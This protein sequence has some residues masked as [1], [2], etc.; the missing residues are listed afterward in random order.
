MDFEDTL[1][2]KHPDGNIEEVYVNN[3]I[4]YDRIR[5]L[6]AYDECDIYRHNAAA[7]NLR[8]TDTIFTVKK[9]STGE[10]VG[11]YSYYNIDSVRAAGYINELKIDP[12]K[13]SSLIN[14][15]VEA[16]KDN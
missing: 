10:I 5:N 14:S 11:T 3:R 8:G 12:S 15:F 1:I 13:I 9:V 4:I 7:R 16:N 6:G 2:I